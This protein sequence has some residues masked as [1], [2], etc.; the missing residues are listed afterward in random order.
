[1][2][3]QTGMKYDSEKSC[4]DLTIRKSRG[5]SSTFF[6]VILHTS[7]AIH[8]LLRSSEVR[9]KFDGFITRSLRISASSTSVST[10]RDLRS[11]TEGPARSPQSIKG[12]EAGI[13]INTELR[14]ISLFCHWSTHGHCP[15]SSFPPALS[16]LESG[17]K[18]CSCSTHVRTILTA[19]GLP[20]TL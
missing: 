4:T 5:S 3:C 11:S 20:P 6:G 10:D 14:P 19:Q 18:A 12:K 17:R 7:L 16:C 13:T 2:D 9:V 15:E 1:M 8:R